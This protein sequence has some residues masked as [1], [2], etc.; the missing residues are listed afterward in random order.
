MNFKNEY[1]FCSKRLLRNID[2]IN[3]IGKCI[4]AVKWKDEFSLESNGINYVHQSGYYKAFDIAFSKYNWSLTPVLSNDPP[5]LAGDYSKNNIFVEVQFGDSTTVFR[6]Y[7]KFH[8]SFT[9]GLASMSVLIVAAN[10]KEF[11][12]TRSKSVQ[13]MIEFDFACKYFRLMPVPVPILLIGLLP[14]N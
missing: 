5:R 3:E 14:E 4:K 2:E 9:N 8:N 11:F 10:P 12:P 6:D 13:G 1:F 7:L